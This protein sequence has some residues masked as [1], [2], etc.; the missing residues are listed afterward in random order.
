MNKYKCAIM[1]YKNMKKIIALLVVV[2]TLSVGGFIFYSYST[3]KKDID[4]PSILQ[5]SSFKFSNLISNKKQSTPPIRHVFVILEENHDWSSIYKNPEAA[6][7]NNTLLKG[8]A[9]ASNYRNV[10]LSYGELH[11]SELNYIFLEAGQISFPDHT[12]STDNDPSLQNSTSYQL[13]LVSLLEKGGYTWKSYQESISGDGCPIKSTGNYAAKHNPFVYFQDVV[14]NPPSSEN[15][16]CKDHIRPLSE[17]QNDLNTGNVANYV[18]ITPNLQ[19]DMHNGT[20]AQG[21][22]WLANT[23][24]QIINSKTFKQ[25]GALFITWDEG[26]E[27]DNNPQQQNNPIGMIMLSPYIKPGFTNN[28]EYSHA[29]L[30]KTI[31]KI[32]ALNPLLGLAKDPNVKDLFDFF[33]QN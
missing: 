1:K 6:Y 19:H 27:Q 2:I 25:D 11:P 4:I 12:F 18:F 7:I 26:S 30:V 29:S 22:A 14:G 23:V 10:P 24:P 3:Q 28:T 16:Y 9:Y 20:I 33:V 13:H 8:G 17:L 31:E 5:K 21:D 15:T 32:F